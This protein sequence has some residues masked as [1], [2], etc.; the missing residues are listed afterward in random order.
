V[1]SGGVGLAMSFP[2]GDEDEGLSTDEWGFVPFGTVGT[3]LG[4]ADLR[5]HAGYEMFT[6][7][8]DEIAPD[9]WIYGVGLFGALAESV[10]VRGE[11]LGQTFDVPGSN[12]DALTFETGADFRLRFGESDLLF[13][14]NGLVG[15]N[16][17][18]VTPDW[19]VGGSVAIDW[20]T[21]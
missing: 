3:N 15:L 1:L 13:R 9:S 19:G 4:M 16:N 2:T 18:D 20:H 14:L 10:A 21:P 5:G 12:P 17:D 11:V 6:D 7:N 8:E